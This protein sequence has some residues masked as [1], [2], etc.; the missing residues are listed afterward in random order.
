[1]S[2]PNRR[3]LYLIENL[4]FLACLVV[5]LALLFAI[6]SLSGKFVVAACLATIMFV[7][8]VLRLTYFGG[9]RP[10]RRGNQGDHRHSEAGWVRAEDGLDI[11][12]N[13]DLAAIQSDIDRY[14]L[15]GLIALAA[16]LSL[17]GIGRPVGSLSTHLL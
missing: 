17:L 7:Q 1:M 8:G 3:R 5:G 13:D 15:V 2:R 14:G 4:A 6:S 9:V 12:W 10:E 16:V 11:E